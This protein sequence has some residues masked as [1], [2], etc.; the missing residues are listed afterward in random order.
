MEITEEQYQRI[1]PLFPVA[2]RK[3]KRSNREVRNAVL[4]LAAQGCQGRGLPE[5]FGNWP[6]VY[7][8]WARWN[9]RGALA[10]VFAARQELGLPSESGA[11]LGLDSASVKV[12]PDT[13]GARRK[14][15]P[16]A[17]G[18]PPGSR[19]T[20]IPGMV[21]DECTPLTITLSPG[22]AHDGVEGRKLLTRRRPP[23]Q[24][25]WRLMARAYAGDATRPL[26]QER[27]A[28]P[29]APPSPG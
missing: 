24:T 23:E 7:M 21:A 26:A 25:A 11:A 5:S 18:Q 14:K 2:R 6:P 15:G 8:R 19:N 27:G 29:A 3:P 4:Y 10:R 22:Q 20:K 16:Q 17:L 9:D 13:A 12:H 28:C 1:S